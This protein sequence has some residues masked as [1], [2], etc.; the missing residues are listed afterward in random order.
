MATPQPTP[1]YLA[2]AKGLAGKVA[3]VAVK[4]PAGT[5]V[6][7]ALSHGLGGPVVGA[8]KVAAFL[9]GK[10]LLLGVCVPV[11]II[12]YTA[13]YSTWNAAKAATLAARR[14]DDALPREGTMSLFAGR[15][16]MVGSLFGPEIAG[17][18]MFGAAASGSSMAASVL[19]RAAFGSVAGGIIQGSVLAWQFQKV[20][21]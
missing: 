15:A 20:T 9:L 3:G 7:G 21:K 5:K 1:T 8:T 12:T 16:G 13:S 11:G 17:F 14:Y 19:K 2:Q 4:A 18:H 6:L 10:P